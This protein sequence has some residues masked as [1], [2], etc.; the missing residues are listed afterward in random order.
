MFGMDR[1]V[2]VSHSHSD[3]VMSHDS[4]SDSDSVPLSV[5]FPLRLYFSSKNINLTR[6]I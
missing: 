2:T 5:A 3:I 4:V 1:S 6:P